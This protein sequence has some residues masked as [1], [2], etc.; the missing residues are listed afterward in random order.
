MSDKI[1]AIVEHSKGKIKEDDE[2][3]LKLAVGVDP[4]SLNVIIDF[5]YPVAWIG[6]SPDNAVDLASVLIKQ[7]GEARAM[8]VERDAS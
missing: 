2:G 1:G 8:L 6:M 5:G 7:A 3:D 4:N